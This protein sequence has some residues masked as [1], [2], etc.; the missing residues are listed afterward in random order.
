MTEQL[1]PTASSTVGPY[2]HIGLTWLNHT[3]MA[4]AATAGRQI[5][6]TGRVIDGN[7]EVVPDAMIELWQANAAGRYDHPEDTRADKAV[8]QT[9]HGYGR[10]RTD[11][12][13]VFRFATVKPGPV[14]GPGNT[15][16]APHIVVALFMRGLLKHL[17]TRIYFA[18]E[19][20]AN[21]ADPILG[22][23]DD[24]G[25]RATLLAQPGANGE[26][27][28]DIVMQGDRETVFFDV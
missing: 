27:R 19:T 17:Y 5:V 24:E 21:A 9:F 20:A 1:I 25:R 2:F 4:T 26:Y 12:D 18:D 22:L 13:G 14:P 15:L 28:W 23:V 6:I 3:E 16:Q 10:S 11:N 8:D 7:G